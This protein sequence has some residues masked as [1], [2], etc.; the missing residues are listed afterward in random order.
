MSK[1]PDSYRA[2]I[3]DKKYQVVEVDRS[4]RVTIIDDRV[5]KDYETFWSILWQ[6]RSLAGFFA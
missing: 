1:N 3:F 2:W 5:F 4:D 6:V